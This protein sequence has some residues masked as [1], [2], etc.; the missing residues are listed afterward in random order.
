MVPVVEREEVLGEGGL[1]SDGEHDVVVMLQLLVHLGWAEGEMLVCHE[2]GD[3]C[4]VKPFVE[5]ESAFGF[6]EFVD[7][8]K[9]R[10]VNLL[11]AYHWDRQGDWLVLGRH[12]WRSDV[13][14]I[15]TRR[16]RIE[17]LRPGLS[18][19]HGCVPERF[20]DL[21]VELFGFLGS[22]LRD[23]E[24][25][26]G[27]IAVDEDHIPD[28]VVPDVHESVFRCLT[29]AA[30]VDVSDRDDCFPVGVDGDFHHSGFVGQV[31]LVVP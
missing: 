16:W 29:N 19:G 5:V 26:L 8:L 4:G 28:L 31:S 30:D 27:F 23:D 11:R 14:A 6:L 12:D 1:P 15:L 2:I 9:L 17:V 25:G 18:A 20:V 10:D 7:G 21:L 24:E 22:R 3:A 13:L